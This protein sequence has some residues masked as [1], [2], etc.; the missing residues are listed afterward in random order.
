MSSLGNGYIEIIGSIVFKGGS[1][2]Y[3]DIHMAFDKA[4]EGFPGSPAELVVPE[5]LKT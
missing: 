5:E 2:G 1:K 4:I 3:I